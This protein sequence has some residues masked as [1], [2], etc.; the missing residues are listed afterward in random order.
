[1][2]EQ[3]GAKL[4]VVFCAVRVAREAQ[5]ACWH[6]SGILNSRLATNEAR[7]TKQNEERAQFISQRAAG[8]GM[9]CWGT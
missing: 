6:V 3:L 1:M 7:S 4:C 8:E 9:M 2:H 5:A